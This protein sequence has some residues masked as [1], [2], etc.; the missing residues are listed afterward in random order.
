MR[1]L[2][3]VLGALAALAAA[4]PAGAATIT[5]R[6]T[7]SGFSPASATID[8][9]DTVTWRNA[10]TT[11][12][13]VVADNGSFASPILAPGK[14]YSF[15]FRTAGRFAYHDAIK[16]SLRARITVKGP[17]PSIT[18][19]AS[20]PIVVS[21]T[22]STVA[23]VVSNRRAGESVTI[24]AQPY[25][26]ASPVQAAVVQSVSGGGFS[27][28]VTPTILTAY[29]AQWRSV[30]SAPVSVQVKPKLTFTPLAGR[31]ST[32]VRSGDHSWAGRFVY[33]QRLSAFG[34]WVTVLKLRL[35]PRSGR[36][37][38]IPRRRGLTT[39]RVFITV[40]QAGAGFLDS[41][42]GTQRLRRR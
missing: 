19:G 30:K 28:T 13:Q 6:I 22:P 41:H 11:N 14:T 4:S 2:L 8:F 40:N 1:R 33:L 15:T 27:Y 25:G 37:F 12:H 5:V 39:Y 23:G 9:G 35:G 24:W 18:L 10:D 16:P 21:G 42:S 29:F 7:K 3:V 26:A 36:I 32:T 20:A 31:F 38:S 17:P 34:Q